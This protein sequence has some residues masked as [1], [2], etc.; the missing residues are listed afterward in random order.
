MPSPRLK[1]L[2]RQTIL[3]TGASSGIGLATARLA[4][5]RGAAVMLVSRNGEELAAIVEEIR[6]RGGRAAFHAADV[7]DRTALEEAARRAEAEL[8][9]IDSWVNDAGS[10]VYGRITEIPE[11]EHRRLFETNYWGVVHGS[12]IAAGL[13][14]ERGGAIVNLG[15]VVSDRAIIFQG[16]YSATKHAVK[17]FTDSIRMEL[18]E[19]GRP[20]SVTLVKPSG[21]DTPFVEHARNR[22]GA[23][24]LAVP[25]PTYDPRL[26]ARA[27]L[28]ACE[29]PVR[30][31]VVGFGGHAI[32]LMGTLFPRAT[33]LLMER[34]G[35]RLQS[36]DSAPRPERADSLET[37]RE[38]GTERSLT[39]P[40]PMRRSSLFLE[41]QM[42]PAATA[43]ALA[44]LGALALGAAA[45]RRMGQGRHLPW[46][47]RRGFPG[48]LFRRFG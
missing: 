40:A 2:A 35:G 48:D 5:Q 18:E 15:S 25:P 17:G 22:L 28:H 11:A 26:V 43:A 38:G 41:A 44:G 1:P 23:P 39:R 16:P 46:G 8:G 6:G 47:R 27:I 12:V 10:S 20:I 31:L 21:I 9:P 45:A 13:L 3:I 19:E 30:D 32:S 29:T 33:D 36:D 42:H 34:F 4:A 14:R 37:P 24:G 7:A